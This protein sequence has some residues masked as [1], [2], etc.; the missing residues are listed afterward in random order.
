MQTT[1]IAFAV[2]SLVLLFIVGM[3][4]WER[5]DF[6]RMCLEGSR[7]QLGELKRLFTLNFERTISEDLAKLR[8][9]AS[10][11][12]FEEKENWIEERRKLL[13]EAYLGLRQDSFM[14]H[15]A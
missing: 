10:K 5:V 3:F 4:A 15:A 12:M 11:E 2:T 8:K 6:A 7:S 1:A 9:V 13:D 14:G